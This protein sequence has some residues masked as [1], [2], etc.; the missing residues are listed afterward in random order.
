MSYFLAHYWAENGHDIVFI[1]HKPYFSSPK[2]VQV[3]NSNIYVY[4]WSSIRRPTSLIDFWHFIKIFYKHKP[5]KVIGHFVGANMSILVSKIL[6]FGRVTTFDYYHTLSSQQVLD[7]KIR[8]FNKFRKYLFYKFLV[9]KVL[10]TSDLALNDYKKFYNLKNGLSHLTPLPDRLPKIVFTSKY[11]KGRLIIGFIGRLD[12]SKGIIEL[13]DAFRKLDKNKFE[14]NIVG[15]GQLTE[16]LTNESI[17]LH[18]INY[19][20]KMTYNQIDDFIQSCDLIII[21]SKSDNLVTVGIETLMNNVCLMLSKNT[22]LVNYL[23]DNECIKIFPEINDIYNKLNY[24]FDNQ[25]V[26]WETAEKGRIKYENVFS[27]NQ[28]FQIMDKIVLSKNGI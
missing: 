10:A 24:L 17:E 16:F 9:N 28:Y 5:K 21:P 26:I 22:G 8:K 19:L 2:I 7:G 23:D 6:S 25:N 4:S 20:G 1:S 3:N 18:N 15:H 13:L 12:K 11:T 14:L 27:L